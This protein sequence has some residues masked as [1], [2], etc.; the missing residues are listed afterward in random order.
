VYVN[1][2]Y[3]GRGI[4]RRLIEAALEEIKA[5]KE[6]IKIRLSVNP[7]QK[8]AVQLYRKCGFK[9]V[10]CLKRELLIDGKFYDELLMEKYL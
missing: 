4:G 9:T 3:R 7:G 10:A 1:V 8:I 5:Q 2:N 6:V